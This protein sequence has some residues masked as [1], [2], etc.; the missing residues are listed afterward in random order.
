MAEL[1]GVSSVG[2]EF[3]RELSVIGGYGFQAMSGRQSSTALTP[4]KSVS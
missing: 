4:S 1:G 3:D 2:E